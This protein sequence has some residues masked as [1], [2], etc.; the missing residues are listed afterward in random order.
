VHRVYTPQRLANVALNRLETRQRVGSPRSYPR[1]L[2]IVLTKA[3]NLNCTFCISS[4]LENARWLEFDLYK[5]IAAELFPHATRLSICSGGEPLLYPQIREVLQI[6]HDYG[7]RTLMV[8]NGML[9]KEDVREWMVEDQTLG[10]Y[11]VSFDGS[12]KE[13]LEKIR[14]GARFET[15]VENVTELAKLRDARG[16]KYPRLGL[17]F[18]AMKSNA[19]DLVGVPALARQMGVEDVLVRY[20]NFANDMTPEDSLY[21]HQDYAAEILERTRAEAEKYGVKMDLPP[22]PRDDE[23]GLRCDAPWEFVQIEADGSV[24]FCYMAWIQ[25]VGNFADGFRQIWQGDIYRKIRTTMES[26]EPFF[27][28]CKHCAMRHGCKNESAHNHGLHR[29]D[30]RFRNSE[31]ITDLTFNKRSEENR[32]SFKKRPKQEA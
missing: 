12:T 4:S 17:R 32:T 30:F 21:F 31:L 13:V 3:C 11:L 26:D 19:E 2:D 24:R 22:L 5:E 14:R 27:P 15:I 25:T 28:Y 7:V 29:D 23:G 10:Q 1:Q 9:M 6:A 16:A 20:V 18:S 8:S